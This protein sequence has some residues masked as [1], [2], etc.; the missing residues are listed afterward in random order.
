MPA[1]PLHAKTFS[2][3]Q[4]LQLGALGAAAAPLLGWQ[5][6][7]ALA[8]P[9]ANRQ[10][11]L[12][13]AH[14]TDIH[15]QPERGAAEG[16]AQC[17]RHVQSHEDP[18]EL[19]VTGGD[20]VMDAFDVDHAR[21]KQLAELWRGILKQD[22]SLPAQHCLGNHDGRGW[23]DSEFAGKAWALEMFGLAKPYHS[24]D[25]GGWRFIV[26]DSVRPL[27]D[28]YTSGLDAEQRTWLEAELEQTPQATPIVVVSH[29]PIIS[30]T[31]FSFDHNAVT[32]DYQRVPGGL[33]HLDGT[34]LHEL[35]KQHGNVKLCLSGHMHLNDRC[36]VDGISY[37]CDGAVCGDWWNGDPRRSD[38]G[39]GLIDLYNDG[40]FDHA[41]TPFNWQVRA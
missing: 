6:D 17:L 10:R 36:D 32:E 39:Y 28:R 24:F 23:D 12:R 22:C 5:A 27:E 2:R 26:L 18:V 35:F 21:S 4:C 7:S 15:V 16:L 41:Y 8:A 29:I 3:R 37:I 13:F 40:T 19:I 20:S 30:V 31:P 14:L 25:Q 33:M 9:A 11:T 1:E 38:E 34:S